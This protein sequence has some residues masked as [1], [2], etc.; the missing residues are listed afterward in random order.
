MTK[1]KKKKKSGSRNPKRK[2]AARKQWLASH[3]DLVGG[4]T[5]KE[6]CQYLGG[7]HSAT[8]R[9]LV[10]RGLLNPNRC[11]RHLVFLKSDLDRF[12]KEGQTV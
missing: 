3:S 11:L 10:Q 6:S 8:V 12:L 7:L 9:R 4:L 5:L 2:A 1:K